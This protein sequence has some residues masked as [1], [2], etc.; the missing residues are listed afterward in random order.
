MSTRF[1]CGTCIGKSQ[2]GL[3]TGPHF[4]AGLFNRL[5]AGRCGGALTARVFSMSL[6]RLLI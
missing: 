6:R 3:K 2:S 1:Q 5:L 4:Y